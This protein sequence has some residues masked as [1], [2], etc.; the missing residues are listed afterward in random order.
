MQHI[1]LSLYLRKN[2]AM[3]FEAEGDY[4]YAVLTFTEYLILIF[5]TSTGKISP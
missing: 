2:H 4:S 1:Q 3:K 5:M